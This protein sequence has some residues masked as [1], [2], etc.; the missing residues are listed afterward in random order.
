MYL[1]HHLKKEDQISLDVLNRSFNGVILIDAQTYEI[2]Y[3]NEAME[4]IF[5]Y[6]QN[7]FIQNGI[8]ILSRN[9]SSETINKHMEQVR[10]GIE[11]N[12]ISKIEHANHTNLY[13]DVRYFLINKNKDYICGILKNIT[14][15]VFYEKEQKYKNTRLNRFLS[16]LHQVSHSPEFQKGN[17]KKSAQS[18]TKLLSEAIDVDRVSIRLYN[19][20]QTELDSLSLYDKKLNQYLEGKHLF[21]KMYED[22]FNYIENKPILTIND[23]DKDEIA[24]K[25]VSDFFS[26]D[27]MI[28]SILMTKIVLEGSVQ[29]YIFFQSWNKIEWD[30]D[31]ILFASQ[32]A[33]YIAILILNHKLRK[34]QE[35]LE[36]KVKLRTEELEISVQKET[37]ANL[38]KRRFLS[39][40]SHELR[41]PL[42]ALIGYLDLVDFTNDTNE[43]KRYIEQ[44][45]VGAHD[46]VSI[47]ND[48]LDFS[49]IESGKITLS[50]TFIELKKVIMQVLNLYDN[51]PKKDEVFF[52]YS[53][54]LSHVY[55]ESDEKILKQV[56]HNLLSNAFKFTKN[57]S[58]KVHVRE[59]NH[60]E[61]HMK[62][63]I[64]EV[65]DTGIGIKESDINRVFQSFEQSFSDPLTH[66]KGTGL[67]LAITK[68][69]VEKLSGS[70]EV[71]S[72]FGV[73]STFK[74]SIPMTHRDKDLTNEYNKVAKTKVFDQK[75]HILIV[76][77]NHINLEI[78]KITL[79]KANHVVDCAINGYEAIRK[80]IAH[81]FDL[82]IMDIHMP[83]LDGTH[84]TQLIRLNPNHSLVKIIALTANA[85]EFS[86]DNYHS[87]GFDGYLVKPVKQNV[88]FDS[89]YSVYNKS[90]QSQSVFVESQDVFAFLKKYVKMNIDEG[91]SYTGNNRTLFFNLIVE[92][93]QTHKETMHKAYQAYTLQDYDVFYR[94][95]H[96]LKG[97]TKLLGFNQIHHVIL[98]LEEAYKND[99]D[100][101]KI[102]EHFDTLIP[103]YECACFCIA[104]IINVFK[105]R[106][107]P[108]G[109]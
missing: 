50:F 108:Y 1:K 41:T 58:I 13:I 15:K 6:N 69:L 16:T 31:T 44:M 17:I 79:E 21:R 24:R 26:S 88:L 5:G 93:S 34:E 48:I 98:S 75:L 43:N 32:I 67:G 9:L 29:G 23:I 22:F 94:N 102:R 89:I 100:H 52:D 60:T 78:L 49:K 18:I 35:F 62:N 51:H 87:Y 12:Y 85:F 57:G 55:F 103:I 80:T 81:K 105:E 30:R 19:E 82:I 25:L 3:L 83:L 97:L 65:Q 59:T 91:L 72:H 33:D 66:P 42:N 53:F 90:I 45:K 4:E 36:E 106:G 84:T 39:H 70:I 71:E 101:P 8:S 104:Y 109:L 38:A 28:V 64:I 11:V 86:E 7:E 40:M 56:L 37:Q 2:I 61:M 20:K 10:Q 63:I 95:I 68:D 54:D 14:E 27:G 107:I 99:K 47:V 77:D 74:V 46:L 73:G 96:S 92:F 76:E